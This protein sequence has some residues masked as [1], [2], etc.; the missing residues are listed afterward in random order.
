MK[1]VGEVI[2]I[3]NPAVGQGRDEE[4]ESDTMLGG[5]ERLRDR[6]LTAASAD[7]VRPEACAFGPG[8]LDPAAFRGRCG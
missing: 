5:L 8:T 7:R 1:P 3:V 6:G 2:R 4:F